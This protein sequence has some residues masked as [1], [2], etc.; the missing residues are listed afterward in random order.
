MTGQS[1]LNEKAIPFRNVK[2]FLYD[3]DATNAFSEILSKEDKLD[4]CNLL[5]NQLT[6]FFK[7]ENFGGDQFFSIIFHNHNAVTGFV[8]R[9]CGI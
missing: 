7:K 8:V 3:D 2:H 4:E 9:M 1:I 6:A 5:G